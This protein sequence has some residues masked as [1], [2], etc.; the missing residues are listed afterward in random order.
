[1]GRFAIRVVLFLACVVP[2][3]ALAEIG[4]QARELMEINEKSAGPS[5]QKVKLALEMAGA[6]RVGQKDRYQALEL[7]VKKIDAE[8]ENRARAIRG[9]ELARHPFNEEEKQALRDQL[10]RLQN[11]CPWRGA[12]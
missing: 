7:E 2:A 4:P 8:P 9:N 3:A 1:M 12:R 6:A 11:A 5:C 10:G